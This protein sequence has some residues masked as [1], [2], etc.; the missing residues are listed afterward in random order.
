MPPGSASVIDRGPCLVVMFVFIRR[1]RPRPAGGQEEDCLRT[2]ADIRLSRLNLNLSVSK[3]IRSLHRRSRRRHRGARWAIAHPLFKVG[4]NHMFWPA[5]FMHGTP[6]SELGA[7]ITRCHYYPFW[8]RATIS[9]STDS[10][11]NDIRSRSHGQIPSLRTTGVLI[12]PLEDSSDR[13]RPS[14]DRQKT[15][16]RH[17]PSSGRQEPSPRPTGASKDKQRTSSDRQ[18]PSSDRQR[19]SLRSTGLSEDRQR[20]SRNQLGPYKNRQRPSSDKLSPS[21]DQQRPS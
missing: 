4:A 5:H 14:S 1:A 18:R 2:P 12:T 21:S 3:I 20:P 8:L 11:I 19:P 16:V 6:N 15:S 17:R 13:Q 7:H 10:P 9:L